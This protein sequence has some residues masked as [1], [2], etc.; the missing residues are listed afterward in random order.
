MIQDFARALIAQLQE[1]IANKTSDMAGGHCKTWEQYQNLTGVIR[2]LSLAEDYIKT[3]AK[4][5]DDNDD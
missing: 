5:A 2:G 3:L 1:E 4:K